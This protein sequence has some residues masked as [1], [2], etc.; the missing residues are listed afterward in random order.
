LTKVL[1]QSQ[2]RTSALWLPIIAAAAA[3]ME[4][5]KFEC[6][7]ETTAW[8]SRAQPTYLAR[9]TVVIAP[10]LGNRTKP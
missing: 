3:A 9:L 7:G 2:G 4:R 5:S 1:V 10:V 8:W 6:L